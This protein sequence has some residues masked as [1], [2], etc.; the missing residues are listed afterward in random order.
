M[1]ESSLEQLISRLILSPTNDVLDRVAS[2]LVSRQNDDIDQMSSSSFQS[3]LTL[4]QWA[5]ETLTRDDQHQMGAYEK[6]FSILSVWNRKVVFE[7]SDVTSKA[8]LLLP[9]NL[10]IIDGIFAQI[11]QRND[12]NDR[13][14]SIVNL[15]FNNLGSLIYRHVHLTRIPVIIYLNERLASDVLMTE[16]FQ[17]YFKE[18]QHP[19]VTFS[20][21]KEFYLNISMLFLETYLHSKPRSIAHNEQQILEYLAHDATK[22]FLLHSTTTSSWSSELLACITHLSGLIEVCVWTKLTGEQMKLLFAVPSTTIYTFLESLIEILSYRPFH[23]LIDPQ[24]VNRETVLIDHLLCILICFVKVTEFSEFF[25]S[26]SKLQETL[27]CFD[28]TSNDR[29]N[30]ITY[31]LQS[32]ILSE[33]EVKKLNI[34]TNVNEVFFHYLEHAWNNPLKMHKNIPIEELLKGKDWRSSSI[35]RWMFFFGSKAF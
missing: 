2:C 7:T 20:P 23:Q 27:L 9:T 28:H 34:A 3:L 12:E 14:L 22:I 24:W 4:E 31:R 19:L 10:E 6:V 21:K 1:E 15:W 35:V 32:D 29:T 11:I 26:H 5:W 25:H 30:L 33:K 16:Q 13:F 17:I 18:L 8:A